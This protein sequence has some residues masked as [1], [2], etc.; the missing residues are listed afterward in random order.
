MQLTYS[1]KEK[2]KELKFVL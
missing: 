1:R 2:P